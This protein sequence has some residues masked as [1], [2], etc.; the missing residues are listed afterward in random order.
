MIPRAQVLAA[1]FHHNK[2][3]QNLLH[4]QAVMIW[5]FMQEAQIFCGGDI[6][7]PPM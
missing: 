7:F 1:S 4:L 6:Y 5:K 3:Y 2:K